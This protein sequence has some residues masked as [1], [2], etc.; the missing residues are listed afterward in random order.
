M[1][2]CF[3]EQDWIMA[4]ELFQEI[5]HAA[6]NH[7]IEGQSNSLDLENKYSSLE[8]YLKNHNATKSSKFWEFYVIDCV[9]DE[10]MTRKQ[11]IIAQVSP[12]KDENDNKRY[13]LVNLLLKYFGEMYSQ[14]RDKEVRGIVQQNVSKNYNLTDDEYKFLNVLFYVKVLSNHTLGK[15]RRT[16]KNTSV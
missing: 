8:F 1:Y 14:T 7:A 12:S 16:Q 5:K 11:D 4:N 9:N 15:V 2:K 6:R 3:K 10:Y 13:S